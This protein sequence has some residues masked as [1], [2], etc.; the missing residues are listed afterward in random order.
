MV[1]EEDDEELEIVT[2]WYSMDIPV[3]NGPGD[4]HGLPGL[5]LEVNEARTTILC[6][7]IVINPEK[8]IEIKAP[9][10]GKEVTQIEFQEIQMKK[11]EER[12]KQF[13]SRDGRREDGHRIQIR[14][15]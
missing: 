14:A 2:A 4:Y 7:K 6:N 12:R 1:V 10:K 5:I 15:N 9:D 8:K 11:M 13:E 3:S